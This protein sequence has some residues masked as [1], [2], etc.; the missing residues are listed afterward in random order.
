MSKLTGFVMP[1]GDRAYFFSGDSYV[2]YDVAADAVDAGYPKPI[3]GNWTGLWAD[4]IDA[5]VVLPTNGK[6]YF[7]RGAESLRYDLDAD[8]A[9]DG[10]PRPIDGSWPGLSGPVDAA[11]A[12]NTGK[13][14][15]L[16]LIHI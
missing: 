10:Y 2:R 14:Y 9:D 16:S 12:W 3:S 6:A 5:V 8:R 1:A 11:I 15:F 4:G 13:V 7:F